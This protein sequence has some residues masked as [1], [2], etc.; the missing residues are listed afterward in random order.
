MSWLF[1]QGRVALL[2]LAVLALEA[3]ALLAWYRRTEHGLAPRDVAA[4]VAPGVG[5]LGAL[6]AAMV[7]AGPLWIGA[8]L[9]LALVAHLADLAR[10]WR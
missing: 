6:Y 5:L 8:A 9:T 10:R 1:E 7:S 4:L 2:V 3:L